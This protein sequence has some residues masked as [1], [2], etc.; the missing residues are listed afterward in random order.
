MSDCTQI[1]TSSKR[2]GSILCNSKPFRNYA[3]LFTNL[4]F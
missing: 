3:Y 1:M 2:M 4:Q